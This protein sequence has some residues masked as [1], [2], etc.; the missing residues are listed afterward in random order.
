[1]D[2]ATTVSLYSQVKDLARQFAGKY[3]E[4]I[5]T[6]IQI[7]LEDEEEIQDFLQSWNQEGYFVI[8]IFM[9]YFDHQVANTLFLRLVRFIEYG[10][11]T[12]YARDREENASHYILASLSKSGLRFFCMVHFS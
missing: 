6:E 10:D 9:K 1:M 5:A 11:A 2:D 3:E 4:G 8:S 7:A 12:L